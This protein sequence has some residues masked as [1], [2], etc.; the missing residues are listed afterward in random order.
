[1]T[2]EVLNGSYETGFRRVHHHSHRNSHSPTH[3]KETLSPPLSVTDE[4]EISTSSSS[5]SSPS[6]IVD[7][8]RYCRKPMKSISVKRQ[9]ASSTISNL[10]DN[11]NDNN[12]ENQEKTTTY[13]TEVI[14]IEEECVKAKREK[15]AQREPLLLPPEQHLVV[16]RKKKASL[17][18]L[19]SRVVAKKQ[20]VEQVRVRR[21]NNSS[22][23]PEQKPVFQESKQLSDCQ[24]GTKVNHMT[25]NGVDSVGR[26]KRED[27]IIENNNIPIDGMYRENSRRT[28]NHHTDEISSR[29]E[30]FSPELQR[31]N[32]KTIKPHSKSPPLQ[33]MVDKDI[34]YQHHHHRSHQRPSRLR[35]YEDQHEHRNRRRVAS[36]SPV[37]DNNDNVYTNKSR[38]TNHK[39]QFF[40]YTS[41]SP[42]L[43][44]SS[45][46]SSTKKTTRIKRERSMSP[47]YE[48]TVE[49]HDVIVDGEEDRERRY[50][51]RLM[52]RKEH[53]QQQHQTSVIRPTAR[54][55]SPRATRYFYPPPPSTTYFTAR[56]RSN[57]KN[58]NNNR[59]PQATASNQL[60]PPSSPFTAT[61]PRTKP[62]LLATSSDNKTNIPPP[63]Y[64]THIKYSKEKVF[65]QQQSTNRRQLNTNERYSK[66]SDSQLQR[67]LVANARERSRVHALSN[68]FEA[69]RGTIPSYSHDQKL[70]KLTIL[71]VAI[72]YIDALTQLLAPKTPDSERRFNQ[73][74]EECT[75]VLQTE[76]GRS[77]K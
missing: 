67:R 26:I 66:L 39:N 29:Y 61:S 25:T 6:L 35:P 33:H 24:D 72:N 65:Q 46:L 17:E 54:R 18:Q 41:S 13:Q 11:N 50:E 51:E 55:A 15:E 45:S 2:Q 16:K 20:K 74:V 52:T 1:M 58:D 69:L 47:S 44:T 4:E 14:D 27:V 62:S 5:S 22:S 75:S 32:H 7:M 59:Q 12:H 9:D 10:D 77:R 56:L 3:L 38:T 71:R 28:Q 37:Y 42:P 68:A 48:L 76:Y 40:R 63:E 43:S 70:S 8:K 23:D 34:E 60:S 30:H 21:E 64:A 31:C 19:L 36:R 73:C 49:D 53:Q 57:N